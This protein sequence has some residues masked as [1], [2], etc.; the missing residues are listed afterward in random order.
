[1][2][3]IKKLFG[4]RMKELR[5]NSGLNQD[6]L[7]ER[8]DITSKYLS[9]IEMGQQF[10]SIDTLVNLANALNVE[11]KDLFEFAH[12]TGGEKDLKNTLDELAEEASEEKLR[13][14]VKVSRAIVK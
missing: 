11:L 1:M 13:M 14:M 5:V 12:L 2:E 7:S 10:P 8:A 6:Q 9:R 4:L 3:E